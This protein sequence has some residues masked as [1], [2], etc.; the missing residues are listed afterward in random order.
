LAATRCV[1]VCVSVCVV[2]VCECLCVCERVCVCAC[3]CVCVRA[4]VRAHIALH[5]TP[6]HCIIVYRRSL[7]D[8]AHG[9][10]NMLPVRTHAP[11]GWTA[12]RLGWPSASGSPQCPPP[13]STSPSSAW[14]RGAVPVVPAV[15]MVVALVAAPSSRSQASRPPP[16]RSRLRSRWA[17]VSS[18]EQVQPTGRDGGRGNV[19]VISSVISIHA[20]PRKH[21][22]FI[23]HAFVACCG[24]CA[25]ACVRVYVCVH[26]RVCV[27][28]CVFARV[29]S[30]VALAWP[31]V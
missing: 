21:P 4:C 31:Q 9:A 27:C 14:T 22:S 3:V 26:L 8:T 25:R 6:L 11:A 24:R 12:G 20:A 2:C 18:T 7:H 19:Q 16:C 15:P 23:C 28:A 1:R 5:Y 17:R 30:C 10:C 13:A 29:R